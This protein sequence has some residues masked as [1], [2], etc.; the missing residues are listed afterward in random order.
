MWGM[1][2]PTALLV[3]GKQ[4]PDRIQEFRGQAALDQYQ[5]STD[6]LGHL[7]LLFMFG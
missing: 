5:V 1:L 2:G 7:S 3:S 6:A 4:F